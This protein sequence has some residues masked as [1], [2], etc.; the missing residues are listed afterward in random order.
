MVNKVLT[1]EYTPNSAALPKVATTI[2]FHLHYG[3]YPYWRILPLSARAH[4][5]KINTHYFNE[6]GS[7]DQIVRSG[8]SKE[9][10]VYLLVL[11]VGQMT[12]DKFYKFYFYD[13]NETTELVQGR[14]TLFIFNTL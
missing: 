11:Q 6:S 13:H 12:N 3:T 5:P 10:V 14:N 8:G 2:L 4:T 1:R 9:K 7:K